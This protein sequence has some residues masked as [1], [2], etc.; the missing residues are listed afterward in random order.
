M[1]S[2]RVELSSPTSSVA[3]LENFSRHVGV[4]HPRPR[5]HPRISL[6][7]RIH[8]HHRRIVV[9]ILNVQRLVGLLGAEVGSARPQI[10]V[11]QMPDHR[12]PGVVQHPLNHAGGSV[13]IASES[14]EHGAMTFVSHHLR[15]AREFLHA[16]RRAVAR[17]QRG[18]EVLQILERAAARMIIPPGVDGPQVILGQHL[19]E[20][21][22][23]RNGRTGTGLRIEAVRAAASLIQQPVV[24]RNPIVRSGHL[25]AGLSADVGRPFG[26]RR[27]ERI[28]PV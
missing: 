19:A 26:G 14:L 20:A 4:I 11:V 21:F 6:V 27:F 22:D 17:V 16:A 15:L 8:H 5:L 28:R 7:E 10:P 24:G 13:L 1:V 3:S 25:H 12:G 9:A 2:T 18:G 23:G